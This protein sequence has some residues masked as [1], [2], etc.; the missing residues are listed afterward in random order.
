[1]IASGCLK[2][3]DSIPIGFHDWKED[4]SNPTLKA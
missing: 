4:T 3:G 1:M 2:P